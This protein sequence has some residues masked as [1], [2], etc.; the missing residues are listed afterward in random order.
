MRTRL[1]MSER[2]FQDLVK[3]YATLNGWLLYH[4]LDSRG[5]SPGFPDLTL[6]RCRPSDLLFAELK[7][8]SGKVR[9]EQLVWIEGLRA[10]GVNA[11]LWRPSDWD[12]ILVRLARPRKDTRAKDVHLP[13]S[14]RVQTADLGPDEHHPRRV[15][16]NPPGKSRRAMRARR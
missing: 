6:L 3:D 1:S 4:T 9:P 13:G 11:Y 15:S 8:E 7:S 16:Y 5:S 10:A 2:E 14:P 12:E